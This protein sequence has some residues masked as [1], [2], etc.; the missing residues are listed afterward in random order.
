MFDVTS[1]HRLLLHP[2]LAP[3]CG[4]DWV[5]PAAGANLS[6]VG[7]NGSALQQGLTNLSFAFVSMES[8]SAALRG[9]EG[10]SVQ[11]LLPVL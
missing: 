5:S 7:W 4:V 1:R 9:N 11:L 8:S 3:W 6:G 10:C 2:A